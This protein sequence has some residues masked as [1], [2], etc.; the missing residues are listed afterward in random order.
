MC[1]FLQAL[2]GA[3]P[4][5]ALEEQKEPETASGQ[6]L[7][8]SEDFDDLS[9]GCLEP[10]SCMLLGPKVGSGVAARP[11]TKQEIQNM[12]E[13]DLS[14]NL[15]SLLGHGESWAFEEDENI[16]LVQTAAK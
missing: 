13:L 11:P 10:Q 15:G 8:C 9:A 14:I 5:L 2:Q 6:T 16:A 3:Q 7:Q 1:C 4:S 12:D